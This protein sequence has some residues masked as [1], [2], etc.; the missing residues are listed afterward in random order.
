MKG[1]QVSR[2]EAGRGELEEE[3]K[4][5]DT[6]LERSG[7]TNDQLEGKGSA[8]DNNGAERQKY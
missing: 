5:K 3:L 7:W 4:E 6:Q 8:R 2:T 1:H